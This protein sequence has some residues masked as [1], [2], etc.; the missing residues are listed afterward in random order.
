MRPRDKHEPHRVA[1]TLELFFDLVF[2]VAVSLAAQTL[3]HLE[4]E[5]HVAVGVGAYLM[6]FFAIWWAWMNFT[7]FAT[8]FDNDDWLYRVTTIAQMAGV[9]VLAAGVEAA[10]VHSDFTA[11]T[12]GYVIMRLA[13]VSQWLRAAVNS[14]E[15]RRTALRYAAGITLVQAAWLLRLLLPEETGVIS[16]VVLAVA[17]VCVPI[18]AEH[19]QVTPFHNHHIAER[20]GLFTLVVLGEGLLGSANAII[21]SLKDTEHIVSLVALAVCSLLIV[22]AMWWLYFATPLHSRFGTLR[23]SLTLGYA[24]YVIFAAAAAM[25]AGIEVLVDFH[26][27]ETELSSVEAAATLT[28]PVAVFVLAVWLTAVR[29]AATAVANTI[30]PL[31][32]VAIAA[33]ALLPS[34]E[35]WTA[36]LLVAIVATLVATGRDGTNRSGV[37]DGSDAD[38]TSASGAGSADTITK[39]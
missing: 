26:G 15:Y 20:F 10:M 34:A 35:I 38:S 14:P 8:A 24:H 2:V 27:G 17:E 33:S 16:F 37:G 31:A 28:V 3:H 5:Q 4:S 39:E 11:V 1:S 22:A 23:Q 36:A 21:D 19:R 30:I 29:P 13:M 7:W 18:W 6:V 9:L 12:W 25:S 32:G